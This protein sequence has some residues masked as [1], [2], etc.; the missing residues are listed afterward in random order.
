MSA[1]SISL[2]TL[3]RTA[4]AD[5]T[6]E[7]FVTA[8]GATCGAGALALGVAR[9]AAASGAVFPLDVVGTAIVEAG[10]AISAG[11]EVQSDSSGRAVTASGGTILGVALQAAA[12]AGSRVEVLLGTQAGGK[13]AQV[14]VSNDVT[15]ITAAGAVPVSGVALVTGGTGFAL[16][17]AAPQ[18]GCRCQIKIAS[19][20]SGSVTVTTPAGVTFDGT[21]NTATCN[22]AADELVLVYKSATQ[23]Q[24]LSNTSVTLSAV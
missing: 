9:S 7:R 12:G 18:P 1:Q 20:A 14:L 19:L 13:L 11:A 3:T 16:T 17:L 5:L 24:V 10:A 22:A 4:A 23:W 21:N 15:V 8:A 6:A 2:L